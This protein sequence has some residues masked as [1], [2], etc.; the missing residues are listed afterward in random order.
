MA[1]VVASDQLAVMIFDRKS[2]ALHHRSSYPLEPH[3]SRL[4]NLAGNT[5]TWED[6]F[7]MALWR[8]GITFSSLPSIRTCL[9]VPTCT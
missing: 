7:R 9:P 8:Y 6:F 1:T 5:P 2:G 4:R 3:D